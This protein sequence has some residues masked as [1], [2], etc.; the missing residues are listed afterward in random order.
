MAETCIVRE[1]HLHEIC[2][3]VNNVGRLS[4]KLDS[5]DPGAAVSIRGVLLK[6]IS[7]LNIDGE[8]FVTGKA[9]RDCDV[10]VSKQQFDVYIAEGDEA[11]ANALRETS[12]LLSARLVALKEL[13]PTG[14]HSRKSTA[15]VKDDATALMSAMHDHLDDVKD[16][17]ATALA[18]Y[19]KALDERN[20]E[21]TAIAAIE[22]DTY[23]QQAA[24]LA[25]GDIGSVEELEA[26]IA[27]QT[28]DRVEL[29][30]KQAEC[31]DKC[32]KK[33]VKITKD[34]VVATLARTAAEATVEAVHKIF[35]CTAQVH[36]ENIAAAKA[37]LDKTR[38]QYLTSVAAAGKQT[39]LFAEML[40][41]KEKQLVEA[42]E[43]TDKLIAS[44]PAKHGHM[45]TVKIILHEEHL[46]T[47]ARLVGAYD[48]IQKDKELLADFKA[49]APEAAL[50]SKFH[51]A[52]S[53]LNGVF[54][55]GQPKSAYLDQKLADSMKHFSAEGSGGDMVAYTLKD[56][57]AK[58]EA[59][60]S[61][62]PSAAPVVIKAAGTEVPRPPTTTTTKVSASSSSTITT[63]TTTTTQK[64]TV[65]KE[66]VTMKKEVSKK[67]A[68]AKQKAAMAET[69]AEMAEAAALAEKAPSDKA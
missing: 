31:V 6:A 28:E 4:A 13:I 7:A 63:S 23:L 41:A 64:T 42:E 43:E 32:L 11:K 56:Q 58:T 12:R 49:D 15:G 40:V 60:A 24:K 39:G 5:L 2:E 65:A 55:H 67:E 8:E 3:M 48:A 61:A 51:D 16:Q 46:T 9:L 45:E 62:A 59:A 35:D 33:V 22:A 37:S 19:K 27:Q 52:E 38:D 17:K 25:A 69:E 1:E 29:L 26:T 44:D 10:A 53:I 47:V 66:T 57:K 68:K 34:E 18:E 21:F 36:D 30:R 54:P 20:S 14:D 50:S